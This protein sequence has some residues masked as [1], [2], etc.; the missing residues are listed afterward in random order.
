MKAGSHPIAYLSQV[1]PSLSTTFTYREM[2]GLRELG[3]DIENFSIWKPSL[4]ELSAEAKHLVT[5]T[6][7]TFPLNIKAFLKAHLYYALKSSIKYLGTLAL[8]LRLPQES[9]KKRI[10]TLAHFGEAVYLSRQME[11]RG[12]RHVHVTFAHTAS[13]AFIISK[14]TD[15]SFSFTAHA[16]DIYANNPPLLPIKLKAAKFVITVSEYNRK[17]LSE[18]AGN[19]D[20]K[21]EIHI[22]H[23]GIDL[24][25]FF[26]ITNKE[27]K[28]QPII[29]SVGR[30][31]EKKGFPYLIKAC[32]ILVEKGCK[33][34]C[35]I[36]GDGPLRSLL[37]NL[38]VQ[39][40][41]SEYVELVGVVFQE[42][43][44]EYFNRAEIFVLP[45]VIAADGDRD[46]VPNVLIEAMAMN[47]PVI[48]T[49][50]IGIPELIRDGKEGLLVPQKD[51]M[52][53][54]DAIA[55][56]IEN[57]DLRQSFGSDGRTRIE[58]DFNLAKTSA[59]LSKIFR[60][61]LI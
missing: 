28:N 14:L 20:G 24:K 38:I 30:L 40:D 61:E 23:Y 42:R 22:V 41:I 13:V 5:E 37:E 59:Q 36:V 4:N 47:I 18:I 60:K 7:Y 12:I 33:F 3:W 29:L 50:I 34:H 11:K 54:A 32:K 19:Y 21:R 39:N 10:R 58:T 55:L 57:N 43:I 27:E 8:V 26:P 52:A 15:I 9:V 25:S 44:R 46:G 6:F 45:C 17:Y 53:L 2:L 16:I 49:D 51:E 1:F 48:S 31:V 56:L 35:Q